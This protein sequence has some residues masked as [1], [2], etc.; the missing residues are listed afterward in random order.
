M[1]QPNRITPGL[2]VTAMRTYDI[3]VP[4]TGFRPATCAEYGCPGYLNGWAS[5]IDEST[6]LGQ[7]Q[8][9]YIR[10][11][12]KLG[13]TEHRNDAGLTVFTFRPGQTP[14]GEGHRRHR[15][16]IDTPEF[17]R[18]RDGDWR[19]NPT[20]RAVM[21]PSAQDWVDDLGEHQER[22]ADMQKRG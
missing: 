17:Y 16:R 4:A 10:T 2:P 19:G 5:T 18:L 7:A 8:A 14:F 21:I 11:E 15:V 22:L 6:E 1:Q 9:R 12:S 13:F 20:G 3:I